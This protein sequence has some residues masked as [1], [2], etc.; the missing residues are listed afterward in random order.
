MVESAIIHLENTSGNASFTLYGINGQVAMTR[1]LGNGDNKISK[2]NLT[3]GL[4]FY[5]IF[6]GNTNIAKGKLRVN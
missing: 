6:D 5:T 3:E 2:E 1:E 4:Y